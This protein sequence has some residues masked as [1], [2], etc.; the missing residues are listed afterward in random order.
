M[1][2]KTVVRRLCK[3]LPDSVELSRVLD[4]EDR[5]EIGEIPVMD[6]DLGVAEEPVPE[7][8]TRTEAVKSKMRSR[9]QVAEEAEPPE[10][11]EREPGEEG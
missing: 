7:K 2:K 9:R 5:A 11:E 3:K 6:V 10:P 8:P 1:A 4:I